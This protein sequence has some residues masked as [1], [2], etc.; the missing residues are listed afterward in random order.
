MKYAIHFKLNGKKNT[1]SFSK[2]DCIKQ[3][4]IIDCPF[5]NPQ[6]VEIKWNRRVHSVDKYLFSMRSGASERASEQ[7]SAV[8]R[9][10]EASSAEQ[11][12]EWAVRANERADEWMALCTLRVDFM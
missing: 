9:A 11:A 1:F 2:V 6:W 5:I 8:E 3:L 7:M 4:Q 12:N 10:S